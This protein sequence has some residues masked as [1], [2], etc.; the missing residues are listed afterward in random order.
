MPSTPPRMAAAS[1]DR[2]GFHTRYSIFDVVPSSLGGASTDMSFSPYTA[3]RARCSSQRSRCDARHQLFFAHFAQ[4][5]IFHP[6]AHTRGAC[7]PFDAFVHFKST[8]PSPAGTYSRLTAQH[9]TPTCDR[10]ETRVT[11]PK[12]RTAHRY[13]P[14]GMAEC[15]AFPSTGVKST[16]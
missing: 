12:G 8:N 11:K 16:I 5:L 2:K 10:G 6:D 13:R 15:R 3:C 14:L 7:V 9:F 4:S 1:L